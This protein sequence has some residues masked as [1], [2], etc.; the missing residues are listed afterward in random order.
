MRATRIALPVVFAI[1]FV[2]ALAPAAPAQQV[3]AGFVSLFNG[4]DFTG[5]KVPAGDNG[6]WKVVDGV[7]DYDAQS[8][9]AGDKNL[10][11]NAEYGDFVLHLEWRIKETPYI[12]PNVPIIR[13]DGTPQEGTGRQGDQDPG[14]RLR[15]GHLPPRL[16]QGAGEHLV[17][18][19]RLGRGVRLPHGPED[20]GRGPRRGDAEG[21]RRQGH[22]RVEHVRDHDEGRPPDRGAQRH[23]RARER[24]VAGRPGARAD[25]A[26]APRRRRRTAC[27]PVRPRSFSS[28]TSGSRNC[29]SHWLVAGPGSG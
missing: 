5:W 15:L 8:E 24:P 14:P 20:A 1:A 17:L 28:A 7:I 16:E 6:H 26:P 21:Q 18:A 9:A 10:W 22:R 25:R 3:P 23:H 2:F 27:G 4:K 19:D 13:L 12:N 29:D 11:S